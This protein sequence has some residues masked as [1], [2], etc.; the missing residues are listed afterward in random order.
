MANKKL[1]GSL[2]NII[3]IIFKGNGN[4]VT[5]Q[6]GSVSYSAARTVTLPNTDQNDE[7]VGTSSPQTLTNKTLS[8]STT[9]IG[10]VGAL[11][12]ALKF[13][14][15]GAT[16]DKTV[17]IA[18]AHTDDRTITL[19]N[20]TG[21]LALTTDVSTHAG[22]TTGVHGVGT[23]AVVG[24]D[25]SQA[26]TNKTIVAASNTISGLLHGTHVDNP[27][28][29]VHGV[30]GSVVGTSDTQTLTNKKLNG[31][32][33]ST[34]NSW[35]I[36]QKNSETGPD[37]ATGSIFLDTSVNKVKAYYNSKWNVI[38]GGLIPTRV[39]GNTSMT[40]G[41]LYVVD[42][43]SATADIEMT[44]P[45]M[46]AEDQ[47]IVL[48]VNN[49]DLTYRVIIKGDTQTINY[50]HVS[51][52]DLKIV[53]S[54]TWVGVVGVQNGGN[55]DI[56]AYDAKVPLNGTL[57]GNLTVSGDLAASTVKSGKF[58][59]GRQTIT[60]TTGTSYNVDFTGT[61]MG[62]SDA[63]VLE[64]GIFFKLG[65]GTA[66]AARFLIMSHGGGTSAFNT[67]AD[68]VNIGATGFTLNSV[69]YVYSGS[70]VYPRINI[71]NSIGG[72]IVCCVNK[73]TSIS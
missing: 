12:K 64:V 23:G 62:L 38:G 15:S 71:T 17:T 43:E 46:A 63:G 34:D 35:L 55:V 8:D 9:V 42:M 13:L 72:D 59:T 37:A 20:A 10:A 24:T 73:L 5:L 61:D 52:N 3:S 51:G 36:P 21:T 65:T 4:N 69:T 22:L 54:E 48:A 30:V 6:P 44:L 68:T 11:T 56:H 29:S 33:A 60:L 50:N 41:K 14:L 58:Y 18:S 25:L 40:A 19:P 67:T 45:P 7:L 70:T 49:A 31:G 53:D 26:L 66:F 32:T 1:F 16:A 39:T 57:S 47:L 2:T 27:S 28:S